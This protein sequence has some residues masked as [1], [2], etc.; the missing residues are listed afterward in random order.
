MK[1]RGFNREPLITEAMALEIA[2]L[3]FIREF[4]SEDFE[5]QQPLT[6]RDEGDSWLIEGS[7][8]YDEDAPRV[9]SQLVDGRTL[10]EIAKHNGAILAL[11]RFAAFADPKDQT[12]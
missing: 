10:I 2:K 3:V 5:R 12:R 1:L 7:R 8:E 4:G 11:E 9:H 6:V